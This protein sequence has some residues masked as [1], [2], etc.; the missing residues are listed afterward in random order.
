MLYL[1]AIVAAAAVSNHN[2]MGVH[3]LS[4]FD[5]GFLERS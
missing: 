3:R 4:H 1:F 5:L 2:F